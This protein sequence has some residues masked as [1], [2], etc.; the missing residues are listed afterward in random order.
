MARLFSYNKAMLAINI[1]SLKN[2][3]SEVLHKVRR[4]KDVLILDRN[5]PVAKI[6]AVTTA[7]VSRDDALLFSELANHGIISGVPRKRLSTAALKKGLAKSSRSAVQALLD[8]RE[9]SR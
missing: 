7:D 6:T 9:E 5:E 1:S 4:G 8:E 2:Q 3:L